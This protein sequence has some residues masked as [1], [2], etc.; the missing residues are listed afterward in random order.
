MDIRMIK[1]VSSRNLIERLR[2]GESSDNDA[3]RARQRF[4]ADSKYV[5]EVRKIVKSLPE[6][7]SQQN[8]AASQPECWVITQ[9]RWMTEHKE[10]KTDPMEVRRV[11]QGCL[12]EYDAWVASNFAEA[13]VT[14]QCAVEAA[15]LEMTVGL[16]EDRAT[17]DAIRHRTPGAW[18]QLVDS[19]MAQI[20]VLRRKA[21]IARVLAR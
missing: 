19:C 5:T 9:F 11:L 17:F 20:E 2:A 16:Q 4:G 15:H 21:H 12:D 8:R 1:H 18:R 14:E 6:S 3:A 7:G 10:A 13:P